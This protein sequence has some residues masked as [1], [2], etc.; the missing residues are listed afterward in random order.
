MRRYLRRSAVFYPVIFL[1]MAS[2]LRAQPIARVT[3]AVAVLQLDSEGA[4]HLTST[5]ELTAPDGQDT[6]LKI[7]GDVG[8]NLIV[9]PHVHSAEEVTLHVEVDVHN[10]LSSV[11]ISRP[12][13][14]E[15]DIRVQEGEVYI[16]PVRG[17]ILIALA[18]K[19]ALLH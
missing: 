12:I 5:T 17:G 16:L 9:R 6:S 11:G 14:N 3:I 7:G 4:R 8:V 15:R 1:L 19:I 2:A 13:I 10:I 18:P